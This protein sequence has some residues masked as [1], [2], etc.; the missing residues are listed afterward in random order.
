MA[1]TCKWFHFLAVLSA[2]AVF[3]GPLIGILLPG[4]APSVNPSISVTQGATNFYNLT[5][6]FGFCISAFVAYVLHWFFPVDFISTTMLEVE[7]G[8]EVV[9]GLPSPHDTEDQHV[10]LGSKDNKE[11]GV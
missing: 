7:T 6:I 10:V 8:G 1:A 11:E 3:I 4:F 2:Y 9:E 5:F